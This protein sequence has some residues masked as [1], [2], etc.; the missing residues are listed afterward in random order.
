MKIDS[1]MCEILVT[2]AAAGQTIREV[3]ASL[4]KDD[5]RRL[6]VCLKQLEASGLVV[7]FHRDHAVRPNYDGAGYKSRPSE[8]AVLSSAQPPAFARSAL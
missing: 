1:P 5:Q 4:K 7:C 2:A 3:M 6:V 8:A